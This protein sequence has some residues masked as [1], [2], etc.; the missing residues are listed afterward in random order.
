MMK[1]GHQEVKKLAQ[2][3]KQR[4]THTHTYTPLSGTMETSWQEVMRAQVGVLTRSGEWGT[5]MSF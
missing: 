1:F 4:D 5:R 2:T 3:A